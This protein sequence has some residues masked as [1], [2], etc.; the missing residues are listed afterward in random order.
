MLKKYRRRLGLSIAMLAILVLITTGVLFTANAAPTPGISL[1]SVSQFD[2]SSFNFSG[3]V[4]PFSGFAAVRIWVN[5]ANGTPLVDSFVPGYPSAYFP[6]QSGNGVILSHIVTFPAQPAGTTLVAR[7]YRA[8]TNTPNSWDQQHYVDTTI[9]CTYGIHAM[10]NYVTCSEW[11]FYGVASPGSGYAAVR[12]WLNKT[13]GT[14]IVDS[15]FNGFPTYYTPIS[16]TGF[17]QGDVHFPAQAP[18]TS[19]LLRLYRTA[20][21]APGSWDNGDIKEFSTTCQNIATATPPP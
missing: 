15:F 10:S 20:D 7:V 18:G 1:L 14:H 13:D 5:S 8:L 9:K 6:V 3:G 2:C 19:L 16:S 4:S 21:P 17:F 12:I 11:A